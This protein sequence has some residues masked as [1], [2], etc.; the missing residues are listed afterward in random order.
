M[1]SRSIDS[2]NTVLVLL[3]IA[4]ALI[5]TGCQMFGEKPIV[6][7]KP[8]KSPYDQPKTWAVAPFIN[9]TSVD[10]DG[11]KFGDKM[12]QQIQ[13]VR[14]VNVVPMG[15]VLETMLARKMAQVDSVEAAMV[16]M[17]ALKVDGIVA[18]TITE[19]NPY[20]PMAIGAIAVLYAPKDGS[21]PQV[22][23]PLQLSRSPSIERLPLFVEANEDRY[24]RVNDY[25]NAADGSVLKRLREYT[26]GRVVPDGP[27]GW[28][29]YLL[30]M[31]LYSSFVSH[32]LV[33]RL[34]EAEAERLA[35]LEATKT[36]TDA[37]GNPT[38]NVGPGSYG[39]LPRP[40]PIPVPLNP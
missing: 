8:I 32:E 15:R 27:S 5:G 16:L 20:D 19:W 37:N 33:D 17:R 35:R 13:R 7:P 24:T 28:R 3:L 18:G 4:G 10:L 25:F 14:G 21:K 26:T 6:Q 9:Q 40:K 38:S 29:R 12:V 1:N 2:R 36:E 23:D 22:I 31:D 39:G 30:D 11:V 34:L